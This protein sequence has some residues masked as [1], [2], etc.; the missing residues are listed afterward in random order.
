MPNTHDIGQQYLDMFGEYPSKHITTSAAIR[1]A[2]DRMNIYM[3][4]LLKTGL[5][6][7]AYGPVAATLYG[8]EKRRV[9]E[10][11]LIISVPRERATNLP[12]SVDA[13][14]IYS[15]SSKYP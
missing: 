1:G 12:K 9:S 2:G 10:L 6:R 15:S 11:L 7:S 3:R 4:A 13:L 14:S 5:I 8:M